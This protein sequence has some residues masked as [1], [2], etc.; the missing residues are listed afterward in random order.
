M[1]ASL[2]QPHPRHDEEIVR[3]RV[4]ELMPPVLT[5]NLV[6]VDLVDAPQVPILFFVQVNRLE[7]VFL[8]GNLGRELGLVV[9]AVEAHFQTGAVLR[10]RL[11]EVHWFEG[12]LCHL[13][14]GG[15]IDAGERGDG[16]VGVVVVFVV[17]LHVVA[18]PV[19]D[20]DV[21][22]EFGGAED[23]AFAEGGGGL[24]EAFS[25]VGAGVG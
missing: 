16:L 5:D 22:G 19:G 2:Q 13:Q 15:L 14:A 8:E 24:E 18:V 6:L 4:T 17:V 7:D 1:L 25:S 10:V 21:V 9:C 3:P 12:F 11:D 23:F 20:G